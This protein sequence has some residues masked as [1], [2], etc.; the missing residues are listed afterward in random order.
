MTEHT[1]DGRGDE[2]VDKE[3]IANQLD[4]SPSTVANWV[5][6]KSHP[7]PKGFK[8]GSGKCS[9]RRWR[10]RVIESWLADLEKDAA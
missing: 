2:L 5:S 10:R 3:W 4:V 8:L 7:M 1:V 6:D 9:P